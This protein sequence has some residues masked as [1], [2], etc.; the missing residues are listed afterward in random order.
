MLI[1]KYTRLGNAAFVPHLDTLRAVTMGIRRIGA[2]AEYSE[3]FNPHMKIFFGQP[4][5][6]GVES[7]CE[8]FCAYVNE[9]PSDFM[10]KLN[11]SLPEGLKILKAGYA[12]K[13]PNVANIMSFADYTITM[14]GI[15]PKISDF[16]R[17]LDEKAL[18]I[19]FEHK[20]ETVQK[21]V[22]PLIADIKATDSR[23]LCMR[24]ACGNRNLRA[25]RLMNFLCER[26]GIAC[27][28]DTIK[29]AMYD[30]NFVNLDKIFFGE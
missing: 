23:T 8:Y 5:P 20:G 17:V 29:T 7:E 16:K 9:D 10:R 6:I 27:A 3:G 15:E 13:D 24:L 19:S 11:A 28:F 14:R 18:V 21:E 1:C 2:K 26:H 4:L 22:R 25:D 30:C 12:E